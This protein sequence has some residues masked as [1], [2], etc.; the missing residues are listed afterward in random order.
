MI[1]AGSVVAWKRI[2]R[3]TSQSNPVIY[4]L[5]LNSSGCSGLNIIQR[6][7]QSF[8]IGVS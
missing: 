6:L 3:H 2:I 7:G 5:N 8:K 4:D 1:L